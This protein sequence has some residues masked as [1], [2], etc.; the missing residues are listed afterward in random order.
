MIYVIMCGGEYGEFEKPK[1]LTL[2]N[3]KPN[4]QRTIE[5]LQACRIYDIYISSNDARFDGFGVPRLEH[6][7]TF[8][9]HDGK[10]EGYWLDAF[11]PNFPEDTEV[12]FLFGDVVFTFEAIQKIINCDRK[13]NTLYGS[14]AAWNRDHKNWGEPFAYVIRDYKTFMA[15][16]SAVKKLQD[17]GKLKRHAIVWELYR[18]LNN[19]DVNVQQVVSKTFITINDGTD[20]IDSLEEQKAMED[21]V[22]K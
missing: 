19:L 9:S 8:K 21:R 4:V 5:M 6:E 17:E 12:T 1:Q 3:G 15:G 11:Y 20:D 14:A 22:W 7:N 16:V 13:G 10:L 2:V 18:Y